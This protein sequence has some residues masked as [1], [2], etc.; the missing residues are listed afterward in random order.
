MSERLPFEGLRNTR[1]LGGM[2]TKDGRCVRRG[3]LIRSGN[4]S[5]ATDA[6]RKKLSAL[7]GTIVDFRT[8]KE[9]SEHPDPEFP[10]VEVFALPV[11]SSLTAGV[12]RDR[13]SDEEAMRILTESAEATRDYMRR[14]YLSFAESPAALSGY[15]AFARL[16][17]RDRPGALLWHCT[18]GKDRAGFAS[19]IAEELLGVS[20]EDIRADYIYT[21]VCLADDIRALTESVSRQIGNRSAEAEASLLAMFSAEL[22]Y[23][24]GL[25]ARIDALW[26]GFEGYL[27]DGLGVTEDMRKNLKKR[28]L[29]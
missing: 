15:S 4:L 13:D 16:L 14:T 9:R 3:L 23:L 24:D 22:T 10:G 7:V 11:I 2:R 29:A 5:T 27:R 25:Y 26:G 28:C 1:D 18:A 6:D 12:T 8:E 19:V 17:C 21:N 20:R